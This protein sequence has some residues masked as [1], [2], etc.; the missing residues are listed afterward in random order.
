MDKAIAPDSSCRQGLGKENILNILNSLITLNTP[1]I[2]NSPITPII[3][4]Y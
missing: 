3:L 1:N 2:L 4:I